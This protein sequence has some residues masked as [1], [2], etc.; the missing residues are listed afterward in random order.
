MPKSAKRSRSPTPRSNKAA[1]AAAPSQSDMAATTTAAVSPDHSKRTPKHV[2]ADTVAEKSK[3][4]HASQLLPEDKNSNNNNNNNSKKRGAPESTTTT[5]AAVTPQPANKRRRVTIERMSSESSTTNNDIPA[6]PTAPPP[7][8]T[9]YLKLLVLGPNGAG[10]QEWIHGLRPKTQE[11]TSETSTTTPYTV[12]YHSKDYS[13]QSS[14][15][16]NETVRLHMYNVDCNAAESDSS[17]PASWKTTLVPSMQHVVL[18]LDLLDVKD[19]E[20]D[21]Q[22][23]K[24]WLERHLTGRQP[25]AGVPVS[26]LLV[27]NNDDDDDTNDR[28]AWFRL[29]A[30]VEK[31]CRYWHINKWYMVDEE[32]AKSSDTILQ[33]LIERTW[34]AMDQQP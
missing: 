25:K 24:Q 3:I 34:T 15:A 22:S 23:W 11:P 2:H 32:G 7:E 31:L 20:K 16:V 8:P 13:F 17:P 10:K 30:T 5:A 28:Q 4:R 12:S 14:A 29:G 19:A 26:L 18:V 1:A 33:T 9:K 21:L 27:N 6:P